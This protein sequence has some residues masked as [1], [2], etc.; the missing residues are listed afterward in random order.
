MF[1]SND[2]NKIQIV[3]N[4][5]FCCLDTGLRLLSPFMPFITEE[6]YQRLPHSDITR[7][8]SVSVAPYPE[9]V[10]III[11]LIIWFTSK[12]HTNIIIIILTF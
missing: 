2:D 9:T 7:Y 12:T 4:V 1:A 3:Q 11:L 6:L 10:S 5:L 8:P